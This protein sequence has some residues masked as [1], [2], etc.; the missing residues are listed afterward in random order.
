MLTKYA[1]YA[2]KGEDI[3]FAHALL[4]A[5]DFHE[6]G[7]DTKLII[8]G[9][10]IKTVV[11]LFDKSKPFANLLEEVRKKGILAAVCRACSKQMGLFEK[12]VSEGLPLGDDMKGHPGMARYVENGYQ[13]I[14]L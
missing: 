4:N 14:V 11:S 12:I 2:F 7:H 6:K 5:L 1:I 9:P 8:E 3:C 13:I 10:A